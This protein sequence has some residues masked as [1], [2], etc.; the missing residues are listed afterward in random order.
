M[1]AEVETMAF[2]GQV[3]WHGLGTALEDADL[4]NWPSACK[5]A[6]LDWDVELDPTRY[7]GHPGQGHSQGS[8]S[9]ERWSNSRMRRPEIRAFAEP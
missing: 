2:F 3:P 6:G 4:Y 8:P 5:K 7:F 1:A 9:Q